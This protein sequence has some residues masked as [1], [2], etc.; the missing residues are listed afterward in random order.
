MPRF[1]DLGDRTM[2]IIKAIYF[3]IRA[4]FVCRLS[5][6]VENLARRQQ[7]AIRAGH[8]V[9]VQRELESSVLTSFVSAT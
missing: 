7:L 3:L 1:G 4:F 5:L 2:G 8:C 6:A 9:L